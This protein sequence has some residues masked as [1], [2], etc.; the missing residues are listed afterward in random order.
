[1]V[2]EG[3]T[4]VMAADQAGFKACVAVLG[5]ALTP[6]HAKQLGTLVGREGSLIML[7]DGDRAGQENAMKAAR[8]CLGAGVP[9]KVSILPD[10]LD[11]A[12]LLAEASAGSE[13]KAV[14]ERVLVSARP[15]FDH[16]LRVLA[17]RPI[18]LDRRAQ[19]A[20]ADQIIAAIRG[21]PDRE[22]RD[23]HLRDAAGW[24]GLPEDGLARRLA[25]EGVAATSEPELAEES[26]D[27]LPQHLDEALHILL[28]VPDLR[29]EAGDGLH[30]EPRHWPKPWSAIAAAL[31]LGDPPDVHAVAADEGVAAV[32]ALVEAV[33]RWT[34]LELSARKPEVGDP[35]TRLSEIAGS[36]HKAELNEA[37]RRLDH[38]LGEAR[39]SGDRERERELLAER[40]ATAKALR[41]R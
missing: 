20:V 10:E 2:M 39:R 12:E 31:L 24:L 16:L 36:I 17:P 19:L 5:T 40:F 29:A 3:P 41:G 28:R 1:V 26:V 14:F 33:H 37:I 15:E 38:D 18:D 7:L 23:L 8:T 4:D 34:A 25:G 32:P 27:P 35:A 22:L 30:L 21:E 13:S 11:P 9:A 6:E